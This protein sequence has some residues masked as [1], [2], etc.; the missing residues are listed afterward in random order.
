MLFVLAF[1]P[2]LGVLT[3]IHPDQIPPNPDWEMGAV[4]ISLTETGRFA[5]PYVIPTGPTAHMPPLYI[6]ASSL[7]YRVLGT[8][9]AGGLARWILVMLVYATLWALMPWLGERLGVGREAGVVGG[10]AGAL[11]LGAPS[12]MVPFVALTL[13]CMLAVFVTRWRGP[14]GSGTRALLLGVG[15]GIAFHLKPALLPVALACMAFELWWSR[16]GRKWL[17]AGLM[18]LGVVLACLPWGWRNYTTFHTVF[19]VRGNLGLELHVGNHEGAHADIDVS[20]ARRGFRHPRIDLGEAER[21]REVGEAAYMGE[22]KEEA[23]AWMRENPG[24]FLKLTAVR[25]VY[26]WS[27]PLHRPGQAAGYLA[28]TLLALVGAW[29]VLP[30][31]DP[32]GRAALVIPLATYPLV[33]YI[34]A[35][36]PEYGE[37]TRWILFLLLGA[38]LWGPSRRADPPCET[39]LQSVP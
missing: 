17:R 35:Y 27:G 12:E 2:R 32:P 4:A 15:L 21:I 8:S 18:M 7:L 1:V 16:E 14:G 30:S 6:W 22:K 11:A 37:P 20:V 19:F 39:S 28:L 13:A 38:A 31:L 10:A 34:V 3:L 24:E 26:Y 36:M 33:Y 5:D 23:L 29:R 9:F 25:A